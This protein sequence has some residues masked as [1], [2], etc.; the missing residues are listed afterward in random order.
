ML[1]TIQTFLLWLPLM[2]LLFKQENYDEKNGISTY[3]GRFVSFTDRLVGHIRDNVGWAF[4]HA[5]RCMGNCLFK[6]I[7]S[8]PPRGN[9]KG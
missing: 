4:T 3:V 7:G 5:G 9:E 8:H 6:Q 1:S 2:I